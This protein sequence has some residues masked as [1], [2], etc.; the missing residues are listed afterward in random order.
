MK[1]SRPIQ[2]V[3]MI[4]GAS[5]GHAAL[6]AAPVNAK[7]KTVS[8]ES[9]FGGVSECCALCSLIGCDNCGSES[10]GV[11]AEATE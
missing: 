6:A 10:V 1:V 3:L 4:L 7:W 11:K 8:C 2:L 9:A 5:V